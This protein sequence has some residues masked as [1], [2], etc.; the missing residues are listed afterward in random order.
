MNPRSRPALVTRARFRRDA[1]RDRHV[2][3]VP[4]GVVALT[5]EGAEITALCDGRRTLSAVSKTV[6]EAHPEAPSEEV[7]ADVEAFVDRL[8]TRGWMVLGEPLPE[9]PVALLAELTYRCPLRCA[10]CSNPTNWRDYGRELDTAGWQRVLREAAELGVLHVHFSGGEPL[11]RDDLED[12]VRAARDAELYTN[13]ITSAWRL[14]PERLDALRRAGL[15]HV[16]VSVQDS[17]AARADAVAGIAL[18][19]E[20]LAAA[21]RVR[22]AGLALSLNVV[23]HRGNV[24]RTGELIALAESVGAQRIELAN[25]QWHGSAATH[26]AALMPSREALE[27]AKAV[28]LRE[29]DRLRGR[30]DVIWVVPDWWEGTPK[31][32]TDGW[33][34][35]FVT[36]VP[37]GT[38]LPCAGAHGLPGMRFDNVAARSLADIW[39]HGEDFARFRGTAWMPAGCATCD[40]RDVDFGGCR[41]QAFALTG[42]PARTDPACAKSPD[43]GLIQA[44]RREPPPPDGPLH[45]IDLRRTS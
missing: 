27:A 16:Q 1:A 15:D 34:R 39:N 28:A 37:D 30:L 42:D 13:L 6:A 36:V 29:R 5:D 14:G 35:S 23:L 8:V 18:H 31:P 12:L 22:D 4:E 10:Y 3:V 11:L 33:G 7:A 2:L 43:H 9:P 45:R 21:R 25:T 19:D 44:L 17:D 40:R 38:V 24:E 32:C 20:K 26:R 41:C